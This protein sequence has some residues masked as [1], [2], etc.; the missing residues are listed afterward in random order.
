[1]M[2]FFH[3]LELGLDRCAR[4]ADSFAHHHT[5]LLVFWLGCAVVGA[6]I[7]SVILDGVNAFRLKRQEQREWRGR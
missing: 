7:A 1:M 5:L 6:L 3:I 4:E 2:Q